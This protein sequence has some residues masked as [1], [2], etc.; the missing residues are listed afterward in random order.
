MV[1]LRRGIPVEI[2][3]NVWLDSVVSSCH[4]FARVSD[5]DRSSVEVA[6]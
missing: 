4:L 3:E 5:S 2:G 6:L 1:V